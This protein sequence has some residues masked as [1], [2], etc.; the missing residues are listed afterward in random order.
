MAAISPSGIESP[1]RAPLRDD[2]PGTLAI[3]H[4]F[5]TNSAFFG[6][7]P[8]LG[9]LTVVGL[10]DCGALEVFFFS[11][12]VSRRVS[13]LRHSPLMASSRHLYDRIRKARQGT[14]MSFRGSHL[15]NKAI[16][17]HISAPNRTCL[18]CDQ[19]GE[20]RADSA[21]PHCLPVVR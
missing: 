10:L 19:V 17:A 2:K 15:P 4:R 9:R 3:N 13:Q 18:L 11:I 7:S 14:G 8:W 6:K 5:G 20:A 12:V 21:R 16:L 1:I